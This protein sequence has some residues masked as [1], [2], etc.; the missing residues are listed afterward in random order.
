MRA[1]TLALVA[2]AGLM[3]VAVRTGASA[4][5][6]GAPAIQP[7]QA[8]ALQQASTIQDICTT[9]A[10]ATHATITVIGGVA[11]TAGAIPVRSS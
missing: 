1:L 9:G 3:T 6:P 11:T 7:S 2:A 4:A 8:A 10:G 5:G